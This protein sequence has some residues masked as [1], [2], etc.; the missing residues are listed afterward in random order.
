MP[1]IELENI[2]KSFSTRRGAGMLLGRGGLADVLRG[3]KHS[4]FQALHDISFTVDHGE[5]V[6]LIGANGAGKSTLLKIIAGVTAPTSG[7]VTVRGR[8]A[9][10]LELGAGFHPLLTGRENVYLNGRILGMSRAEV[11]NVFDDIVAFSGLEEFIDNP[12]D[13][14]SS[15]MFVRLGFAVAVHSNPDIFLVDEVLSVGDEDFQRKC[16]ERIG[17]LRSQDKTIL[18]VSHD[19][20]IVNTLCDRVILLSGGTMFVRGTVQETIDFYL[21]QIG[22][23]KGIHTIASPSAEAI[24]SHGRISAFHNRKEISATSGFQVHLR[25]MGFVHA[26]PSADWNV[27]ARSEN[28]CVAVGKMPRLPITHTWRLQLNGSTLTWSIEVECERAVQVE[29]IDVNLFVKKSF[30][31]WQYRDETGAFPEIPLQQQTYLEIVPGDA[32]VREAGAFSDDPGGPSP[33]SIEAVGQ[34]KPHRLQW[35]NTDYAVGCRVLQVLFNDL[36]PENIMAAGR[37]ELVTLEIN[38]GADR[39]TILGYRAK[40]VRGTALNDGDL[41]L[42]F[43]DGRFTLEWRGEELTRT[44]ALYTSILTHK[45]W[46]DSDKLHW[47]YVECSGSV[48]RVTGRSRRFPFAQHWELDLRDSALYLTIWLEVF[49]DFDMD[50]CHTSIGLR[51]EYD[52]WKTDHESGEF[53]PFEQG[54]ED[55]RHVN[56]EYATGAT[57]C[58]LSPNLP[59]VM[60][61]STAGGVSFRMTVLNTGFSDNTRVLQA[62]RTPDAGRLR[63][64]PGRHLYFQGL[65][66]VEPQ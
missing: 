58:A 23:K 52:R 4:T 40:Y 44:V 45:I 14:Y 17:E 59:S 20:S 22:Q 35:S 12:V 6:G 43:A 9:S 42:R 2:S 31:R 37:H 7:R 36:G 39:E 64:A 21:R 50:E 26:S 24:V 49:D 15:G 61:K 62:L 11:D 66:R 56:K 1:L 5:S 10:L 57:A 19:L 47:G 3:R 55:W 8:V 33:V 34:S 18:F 16:R 28:G 38:L 63:F 53:P 60:L 51:P 65:V 46:N 29:G 13:T 32:V 25:S 30:T 48:M 27:V 54:L 41:T